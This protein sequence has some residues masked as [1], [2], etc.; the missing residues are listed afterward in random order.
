MNNFR[1]GA[2]KLSELRNRNKLEDLLEKRD[3]LDIEIDRVIHK[4]TKIEDRVYKEK[5]S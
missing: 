2:L 4:I 1:M 5:L 3:K